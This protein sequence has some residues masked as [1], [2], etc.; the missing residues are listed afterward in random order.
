MHQQLQTTLVVLTTA[1]AIEHDTACQRYCVHAVLP[2]LG[3]M[4]GTATLH[5]IQPKD[6]LRVSIS[7]SNGHICLDILYDGQNGGWSPA[8]TINKVCLS[9]R[10]ML[11]SNTEKVRHLTRMRGC[12]GVSF[13][14]LC[15]NM[16]SQN[17]LSCC[18]AGC[19]SCCL[20]ACRMLCLLH[21]AP[22]WGHICGRCVVAYMCGT[23]TIPPSAAVAAATA[24]FCC[25]AA[26]AWRPRVLLAC[27][28]H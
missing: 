20:G 25:T 17:A 7:C 6:L 24:L 1:A 8:L 14:L 11:A 28:V 15:P 18:L 13:A 21:F 19:P 22:L 16:F 10:S 2:V 3:C 26:A 9:L 27:A 4:M 5:S 12:G 23:H